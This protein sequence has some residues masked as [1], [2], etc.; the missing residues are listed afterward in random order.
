MGSHRVGHNWS[1]LA[2]AAATSSYST[3]GHLSKEHK[4]TNL[5]K[6]TQPYVHGSIIY[7]SQ[8]TEIAQV[9]LSEWMD[10]D[11]VYIHNRLRYLKN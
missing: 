2:G 5:K 10:K 11:V 3:S 4:N 1:D 7:N 9:P 8:N 6:H